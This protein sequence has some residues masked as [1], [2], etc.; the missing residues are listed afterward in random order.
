MFVT[1]I[2]A[3]GRNNSFNAELQ[4]GAKQQLPDGV[5]KPFQ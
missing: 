1:L 2:S 3:V 4:V 5:A